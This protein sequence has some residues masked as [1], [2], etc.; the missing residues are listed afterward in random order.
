[1]DHNS[2][3]L[4]TR[5]RQLQA[6]GDL[7]SG[8]E[9]EIGAPQFTPPYNEIYQAIINASAGDGYTALMHL[10]LAQPEWS[11]TIEE[12]FRVEPGAGLR[13]PPLKELEDQLGQTEWLWPEWLPAGHLSLLAASPGVGKTY[14]ALDLAR[15]V[16][17]G[18]AAPDQAALNCR[19]R[20]N[21]IYVDAEDF[22]P[23]VHERV[24]AWQMDTRRFFPLRRPSRDL[25]DLSAPWHQD[26]LLDMAYD[27]APALIIVDSLSTVNRRGEN[28]IEDLREI[29]GFFI[30]L[31]QHFNCAVIVIHHLRKPPRGL[32]TQ[33]ISMHDLRGSGHLVAM[34]RTIMAMDV[35]KTG[36]DDDPNGPRLLKLLKSN[37]GK[38]PRPLAV[39][40]DP[41]A[42]STVVQ[43]R[44][45]QLDQWHNESTTTLTEQ[46]AD[47][48]VSLLTAE[49]QPYA[50]IREAAREAGFK[51]NVLQNARRQ[52]GGQITDTVGPRRK[53]N[54]WQ[55]VRPEA[56]APPD[57]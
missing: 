18:L 23:I 7:L 48:L 46:C 52:L 45:E 6:L 43:L 14:V 41:V 47:W 44:Y 3:P 36:P 51:E 21:V 29:L 49:P 17:D 57:P 55:F 50:V 32:V 33:P 35:L 30:D 53:G 25:L 15:R 13:H 5:R 12:I 8:R 20:H 40:F 16:T 34:A 54:K 56:T 19:Q 22:L 31:A 1:M 2:Y 38:I 39:H 27:L 28:N 24:Q 10:K 11:D 42:D 37:L 9:P 4:L 26:R